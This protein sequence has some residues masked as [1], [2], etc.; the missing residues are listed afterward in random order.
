MSCTPM[1]YSSLISKSKLTGIHHPA[2]AV[3]FVWVGLRTSMTRIAMLAGVF[4]LLVGPSKSNRLKDRGQASS[5]S[6][7]FFFTFLLFYSFISPI[8]MLF[9]SIYNLYALLGRKA[10]FTHYW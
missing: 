6:H 5:S 2:R 9:S 1:I 3:T 10:P 4:I 7:F 8:S